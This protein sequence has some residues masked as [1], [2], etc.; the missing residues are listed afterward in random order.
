MV[1]FHLPS[2]PTDNEEAARASVVMMHSTHPSPSQPTQA[3]DRFNINRSWEH[4]QN[5]YVG[6]GHPDLTKQ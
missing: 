4:L 1:S 5:K 3:A 6:T 2:P